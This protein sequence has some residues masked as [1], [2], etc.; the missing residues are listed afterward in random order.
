MLLLATF[1]LNHLLLMQHV[2]GGHVVDLIVHHHRHQVAQHLTLHVIMA[3]MSIFRMIERNTLKSMPN[4]SLYQN[5]NM[6]DRS[7]LAGL[8]ESPPAPGD[9]PS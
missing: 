3:T 2:V 6:K 7:R 1:L 9:L 4:R 5:D 8:P